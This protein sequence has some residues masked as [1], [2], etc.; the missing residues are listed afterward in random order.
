MK[1]KKIL[2]LLTFS[3]G[4]LFLIMI[5][6]NLK[7]AILFAIT[8]LGFNFIIFKNNIFNF[9]LSVFLFPF[10]SL[11]FYFQSKESSINF[12]KSDYLS[13]IEFQTYTI[14][15]E[16]INLAPFFATLSYGTLEEKRNLPYLL[17]KLYLENKVQEDIVFY[18]INVLMNENHHPDI[19][20]AASD[21]LT[22]IEGY[23]LDKLEESFKK[24]D[25]LEGLIDY[26]TYALKYIKSGFLF[27]EQKTEFIE[28]IEKILYEGLESYPKNSTLIICLLSIL[29]EKNEFL[30]IENILNDYLNNKLYNVPILDFAVLYYIR[31]RKYKELKVLLQKIENYDL[32][33]FSDT[34]KYLLEGNY[35]TRA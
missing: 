2:F 11:I 9:L 34:T 14:N 8:Y 32:S 5:F 1:T 22:Q 35:E 18:M 24:I 17:Y 27:G 28:K 26:S 31:Q 33:N 3:W 4:I 15:K 30:K 25:S 19:I 23:L 7:I 12:N 16:I 21:A 13:D 20:L 10:Y 6:F 29:L